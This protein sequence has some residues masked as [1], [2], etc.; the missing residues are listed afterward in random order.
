MSKLTI[1]FYSNNTPRPHV[2]LHSATE[3]YQ[4]VRTH[5]DHT[6]YCTPQLKT[7][8]KTVINGSGPQNTMMK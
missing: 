6:F 2:L 3:I 5:K 4:M 7:I 8:S 1:V